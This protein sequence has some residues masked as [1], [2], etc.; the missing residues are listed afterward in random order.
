METVKLGNHVLPVVPQRHARLR[1]RLGPE[2]FQRLL[3]SDYAHE[4]YRVL[5]ILIPALHE[6]VPEWEWEGYASQEAREKDEYVEE[7]DKSPLTSEIVD[8]FEKALM[9]SGAGRLGKLIDL[10]QTGQ[11]MT[12]TQQAQAA[13]AVTAP[14]APMPSS[15]DS[16]GGN[17]E[18]A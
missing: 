7:L 16:P 3:S 9:V 2:D 11:K 10:I 14:V 5:G 4:T 17:G 6:Q 1:H 15:P 13:T 12:E 18:S 8:A